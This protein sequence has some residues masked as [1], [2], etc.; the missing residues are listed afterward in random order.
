MLSIATRAERLKCLEAA[1][2]NLFFVPA[3][4]VMIDLLTDSGTGSLSAGQWAGMMMADESYAAAD[5]WF[6]FE[7]AVQDIFGF[8]HV[9]PT[10][11]V[12][13]TAR[14]D[15]QFF[16][17]GPLG[18]D[19]RCRKSDADRLTQHFFNSLT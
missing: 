11:Q 2:N 16:S 14:S 19:G 10:H 17:E 1:H 13:A 12:S 5:S 4:D 8:D 15:A 9:I 7:A 18:A 6:R 3:R